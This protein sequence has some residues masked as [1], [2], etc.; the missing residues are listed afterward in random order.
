MFDDT[1]I[2]QLAAHHELMITVEEG[3][4]GGFGSF[5][6]QFLSENG[7]LD[8]ALKFRS[9]VLPD[10]YQEHD[11]PEKMY[12]EAGLDAAGIVA[13]VRAAL[14]MPEAEQAVRA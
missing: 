13:K 3:S 7:L 9:M 14:G 8:G 11:K 4:V 1:L 2:R 10:I 12:A 5:V 6:A